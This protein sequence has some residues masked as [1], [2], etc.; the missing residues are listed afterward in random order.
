MGDNYYDP[1]TFDHNDYDGV[2]IGLVRKKEEKKLLNFFSNSW[3]S[4]W[5]K[6][7]IVKACE[8][9]GWKEP[10]EKVSK[11]RHGD[12]PEYLKTLAKNALER[13]KGQQANRRRGLPS[14][15]KAQ[16]QTKR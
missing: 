5:A 10:L 13:M 9:S 6:I 2:G 1:V 7:K 3:Y 16:V 11:D 14:Q 15:M 8:D 4:S 12:Y